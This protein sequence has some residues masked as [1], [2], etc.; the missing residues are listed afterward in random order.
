MSITVNAQ[1]I[2]NPYMHGAGSIGATY[3]HQS[4]TFTLPAGQDSVTV[5]ITSVPMNRTM[6]TW[7]PAMVESVGVSGQ[8]GGV[9][10]VMIADNTLLFFREE[11]TGCGPVS[12]QYYARTD[13]DNTVQHGLVTVPIDS[14]VKNVTIT[15][16]TLANTWSYLTGVWETSTTSWNG[17]ASVTLEQ[18][19]TTNLRFTSYSATAI[20]QRFGYQVVTNANFTVTRG[21][22]GS[23]TSSFKVP[24]TSVGDST[25]AIISGTSF[26]NANSGQR[27]S[28]NSLVDNVDTAAVTYGNTGSG[29]Q[30]A[31]QA[32]RIANA[33]IYPVPIAFGIGDLS[34]MASIGASVNT[35]LAMIFGNGFMNWGGKTGS[36]TANRGPFTSPFTFS[37]PS[38]VQG[39]RLFHGAATYDP[40]PHVIV[41]D[42]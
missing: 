22:T 4:G 5:T 38:Q 39:T 28:G 25:E 16:S 35:A 31:Y 32:V 11:D 12:G 34:A 24:I 26:V 33:K 42:P 14:S 20:T 23:S 41:W 2:I 15:A 21:D 30:Y 27:I 9:L 36:A 3:S 18:T 40:V 37:T 19:S 17:N 13:S 10:G 6:W 1:D 29:R 7:Q 8:C